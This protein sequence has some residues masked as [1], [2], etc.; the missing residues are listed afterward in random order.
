MTMKWAKSVVFFLMGLVHLTHKG[1]RSKVYLNMMK[2]ADL[3]KKCSLKLLAIGPKALK[4]I[5]NFLR[6]LH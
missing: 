2:M 5:S 6:L 3:S 1:K 4:N